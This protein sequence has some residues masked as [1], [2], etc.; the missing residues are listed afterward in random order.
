MEM[1]N[2]DIRR[3]YEAAADKKKQVKIL[4]D[5][6]QTTPEKIIEILKSEGVDHRSLPR[7]KKAPQEE[8]AVAPVEA[9]RPRVTPRRIHDLRRM[10]E[11]F[12]A[13]GEEVL[14]GRVPPSDWLIEFDDLYCRYQWRGG[15][16]ANG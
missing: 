4:A 12:A 8:L 2:A 1:C 13:I 5:L 15:P 7:V 16:D 9:E 14:L 10:C 6:N 3:D 11:L